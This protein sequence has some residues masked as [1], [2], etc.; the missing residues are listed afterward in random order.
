MICDIDVHLSYGVQ[1]MTDI[2]MQIEVAA[3]PDQEILSASFDVSDTEHFGRVSAEAGIGNRIWV[4]TSTNLVCHYQARIAITRPDEDLSKLEVSLPHLLP[5]DTVRYLMPSLYCPA[6][7]FQS[8]VAMEFGH[9]IGGDRVK[10]MRDW[11]ASHLSYVQGS[12][13][14]DTT[15]RETFVRRQGVCRDYAHLLITLARA[16]GIPAR[17]TSVYAPGVNPPDFHAVAEVYLSGAWHLVDATGMASP[18]S[19]AVIGVGCDAAEVAFL[20]SFGPVQLLQQSVSA[21]ISQ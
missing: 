19:I 20:S 17:Y 16:S 11:I 13:G 5:G 12:S 7:E 4:H 8:F 10:A 21:T 1:G 9:L 14:E 15:A 2:L 3:L 18:D 6:A